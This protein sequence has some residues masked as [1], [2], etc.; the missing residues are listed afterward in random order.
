LFNFYVFDGIKFD[1]WYIFVNLLCYHAV[2]VFSFQYL[3]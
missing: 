2:C 3:F 1:S